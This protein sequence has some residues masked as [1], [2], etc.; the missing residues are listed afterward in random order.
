MSD[1]HDRVEIRGRD[2]ADHSGSGHG[3]DDLV[4]ARYTGPSQLDHLFRIR[5]KVTNSY[6]PIRIP[7]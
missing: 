7:M 4:G 3:A 6:F 2:G 1:G 5:R